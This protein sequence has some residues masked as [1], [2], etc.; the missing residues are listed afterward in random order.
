MLSEDEEESGILSPIDWTSLV[1][2]LEEAVVSLMA[3]FAIWTST[4]WLDIFLPMI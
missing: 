2:G 3:F 4:V 1:L